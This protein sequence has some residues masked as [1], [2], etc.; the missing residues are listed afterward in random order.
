MG[1]TIAGGIKTRETNMERYG[2]DYYKKIGKK[3]G[4]T[5]RGGQFTDRALAS[6]WGAVGGAK[7]RRVKAD[8]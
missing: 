2:E 6:K 8:Y 4:Q 1:G 7:S 5:S 3:G